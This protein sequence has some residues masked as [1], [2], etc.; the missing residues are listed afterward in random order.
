MSNDIVSSIA[1]KLLSEIQTSQALVI[2]WHAGEPT[3]VPIKWY[4][5]ATSLFTHV[6][7]V[8]SIQF[9]L[10]SNGIGLDESWIEFLTTTRT[11]LGLSIDGPE[12]IHDK[13]RLTKKGG[14]T[15]HLAVRALRRAQSQGLDPSVISVLTDYA[16]DYPIQFFD[17]Y[18][19]HN[20]THVSISIEEIEGRNVRSTL[21]SVQN[22]EERVEAFYYKLMNAAVRERYPLFIRESENILKK[23]LFTE[24]APVDSIA[25]EQV[26]PFSMITVT[27]NGDLYTFSPELSEHYDPKEGAVPLGNVSRLNPNHIYNTAAFKLLSSNIEAGTTLCRSS[28]S[29]WQFCGGGAP[30]N[31]LSEHGTFRKSETLFCKLTTQAMIRSM[32]RLFAPSTRENGE[33]K[34]QPTS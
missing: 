26:I 32:S 34:C 20:I 21:L 19:R 1:S 10:Q 7:P 25:N 4:E 2:V 17:F 22:L 29:Y 24:M 28:C 33:R 11:S 23:I 5:S 8:P 16:L 27:Y 12:Y 9:A 31:R 18:K 15:W 6:R 13:Y 30:V 3:T 14:P